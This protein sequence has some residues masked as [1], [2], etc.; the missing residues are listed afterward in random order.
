MNNYD[1]LET[2]V[3]VVGSE[4]AQ[5]YGD[6]AFLGVFGRVLSRTAAKKNVNLSQLGLKD[7]DSTQISKTLN[8]LLAFRFKE[9]SPNRLV[10]M[11]PNKDIDTLSSSRSRLNLANMIGQT[12]W[13]NQKILVV[14]PPPRNLDDN[15]TISQL[16]NALADVC[17]RRGIQYINLF[18][19][20]K[21]E[22]G[23][24]HAMLESDGK[25][26]NETAYGLVAAHI[27]NSNFEQFFN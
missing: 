10:I 22:P 26:P 3:V 17:A 27:I 11:F 7:A 8:D 2:N 19:L 4:L 1:P 24:S 23:W 14:G 18:N 12:M 13:P 21:N 20:L 15:M 6:P 25:Y 5:G 9:D 16:S